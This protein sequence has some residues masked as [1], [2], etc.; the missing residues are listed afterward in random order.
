MGMCEDNR[1]VDRL[2]GLFCVER[3]RYV[4]AFRGNENLVSLAFR[5][6]RRSE[7]AWCKAHALLIFFFVILLEADVFRTLDSPV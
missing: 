3:E 7:T 2:V 6:A 5:I 1:G 4:T